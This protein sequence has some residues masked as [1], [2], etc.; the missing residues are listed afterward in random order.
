MTK[1]NAEFKFDL[2]NAV[3]ANAIFWFLFAK[4]LKFLKIDLSR[5]FIGNDYITC[6]IKIKPGK[7][8]LLKYNSRRYMISRAV[9]LETTKVCRRY[10]TSRVLFLVTT[11]V[12]TLKFHTACHTA[13]FCYLHTKMCYF[14]EALLTN[15]S[16]ITDLSAISSTYNVFW[17]RFNGMGAQ[18]NAPKKFL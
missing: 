16:V 2:T 1:F 5:I 17:Y 7:N 14:L 4:N 12:A 6:N 11:K 3:Y 18:K 8:L 10:M 13:I 15:T 9:P